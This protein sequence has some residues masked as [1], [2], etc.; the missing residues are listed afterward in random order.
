MSLQKFP[1]LN[2]SS[3][4]LR[5]YLDTRYDDGSQEGYIVLLCGHAGTCA[6]ISWSTN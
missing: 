4:H 6:P 1:P 3:L 2:F 5:V